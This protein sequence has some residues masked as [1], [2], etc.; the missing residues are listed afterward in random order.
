MR[1]SRD[2][3]DEPLRDDTKRDLKKGIVKDADK[4][5]SREWDTIHGDGSTLGLDNRGTESG[6]RD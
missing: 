6:K 3:G 5:E 2:F 4:T 1:S